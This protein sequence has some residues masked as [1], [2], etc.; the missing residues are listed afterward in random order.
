VSRSPDKRV[1][2]AWFV[3]T[4]AIGGAAGFLL[5]EVIV[6]IGRWL[7]MFEGGYVADVGRIAFY[8]AGFGLA[9]GAALGAT[10]GWVRE[11]RQQ[12]GYGLAVGAVLGLAGGFVG[13]GVGQAIYGLA[14][15]PG[16]KVDVAIAID[17]SGSMGGA[18]LIFAT[19]NDP[20]GARITAAVELIDRLS[21]TDRV[22]VV[23]FDGYAKLLLPLT[24]LDSQDARQRARL[25]IRRIDSAGSTDLDAGLRSS[26]QELEGK[27]EEGRRRHV[28]FLTD[29]EGHFDPATIAEAAGL[30]IAIHT[31]GLGREVDAALLQT[32]AEQTGGRYYP[33]EDA[34]RLSDVFG[35]IFER[36]LDM[37]R[38]QLGSSSAGGSGV[39]GSIL[40]YLLRVLSWAAMGLSIGAGQ[41]VRENTREDLRACAYGGLV[42]GILGGVLFDPIAGAV[43]FASGF[44][45]R[46]LG[47]VVVGAAIGG[48]MRLLQPTIVDPEAA[49]TQLTSILPAKGGL[50]VQE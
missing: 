12:L 20:N 21:D 8:F 14:A 43:T 13:G 15:G 44:F 50:V 4:G 26:I 19:G 30:E 37:T 46:L 32:I 28:I 18:F 24:L 47:D 38:S 40:L 22:T 35:S 16:S 7:G 2:S 49:S 27:R 31:I 5:M 34:D 23:D 17:S 41:G 11:D 9:V 3:L 36:D 42:G 1:R 33:V 45:G 6:A 29:G 48:S 39:G 10:E 25:A